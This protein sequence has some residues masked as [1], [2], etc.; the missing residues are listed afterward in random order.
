MNGKLQGALAL[1]LQLPMSGLARSW[2]RLSRRLRGK[3]DRGLQPVRLP[4]V[5][6]QQLTGRRWPGLLEPSK[7]NGN[8]RISELA[9]LNALAGD[10]PDG[11]MLFEIGTF[12]GRTTVNLAAASPPGCTVCTLDLPPDVDTA[13]ALAP[14]ERHMVD[15]PE[16]GARIRSYRETGA[17][18]A[19]RIRQLYGDSGTFDFSPHEGRCGLVFV[20]GSHAADYVRSDSRAAFRLLREGGL[21]VWHDYGIWQDVTTTLESLAEQDGLPIRYVRGTSLAVCRKQTEY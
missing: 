20:D 18:F 8:V 13:H 7:A 1:Y 19:A 10:V 3:R 9:I 2:R 21:V 12:D 14:G 4:P 5:R 15:K 16:S 11:D 6:W 17:P